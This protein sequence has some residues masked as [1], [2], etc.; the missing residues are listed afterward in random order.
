MIM[1]YPY[2]YITVNN[3]ICTNIHI[4]AK[5]LINTGSN[6]IILFM[7]WSITQIHEQLF[8]YYSDSSL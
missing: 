3:K 8:I 6:G 5:T 2:G 1:L 4:L 7:H